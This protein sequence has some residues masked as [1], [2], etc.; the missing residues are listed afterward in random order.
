MFGGWILFLKQKMPMLSGWDLRIP[1]MRLKLQQKGAFLAGTK[2]AIGLMCDRGFPRTGLG[3][4]IN[5]DLVA[6]CT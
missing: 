3:T 2:K 6:L 4:R 5:R 1:T